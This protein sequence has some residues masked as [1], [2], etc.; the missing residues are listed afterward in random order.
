MECS[1]E[2]ENVYKSNGYY[3]PGLERKV[4]IVFDFTQYSLRHLFR[5]RKLIIN[6][7]FITQSYSPVLKDLGLSSITY[8]L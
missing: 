7:I 6:L 4:Y 5:G 2:L 8:F 1:N 3:N